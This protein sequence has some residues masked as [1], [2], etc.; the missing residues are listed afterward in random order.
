MK[1]RFGGKTSTLTVETKNGI[2]VV[3]AADLEVGGK[4]RTKGEY[5]TEEINRISNYITDKSSVLIVGA[6][7]GSLA[8]PI[9]K[10][11]S[12]LVAIEA[13]PRNFDLLQ[14][15]IELNK[16]TNL[17][18]YNI[19]ASD[20]SE[21]IKFQMNT[22]NSGGS[23]RVPV[24][25]HYMYTYDNPEVIDVEAHSLDNYLS[26]T[27]FDLVLIDIEGS[28]Y[29]AMRGMKEILT[30]TKTLIVEFLP[31]HITNVAG[32]RLTDFLDNIPQHL[33]QITIP[34]RNATYPIDVGI[35]TL[36]QM[37]DNGDGDDGIIFHN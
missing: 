28:E 13:N 19:A 9:A 3:D 29:F 7:I 35:V 4:L 26:N 11:C 12:K 32:I 24:N 15:N 31:H 10:K 37:F 33:G 21:T 34:S 6:H 30:N 18:A 23:K 5:G 20:K 1:R 16:I 14:K 36:R 8:I 17:T 22:V 25:N 27:S 2:F